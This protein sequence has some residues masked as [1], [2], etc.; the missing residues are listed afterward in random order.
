MATT[1]TVTVTLVGGPADWR[2]RTLPYGPDTLAADEPGAYLISDY[3]PHREDWEDTSPRAV[4]TADEDSPRVWRFRGWFPASVHDP[5]PS[6]YDR[7]D[8]A[9]LYPALTRIGITATAVH[10][11]VHT[12]LVDLLDDLDDEDPDE[13]LDALTTAIGDEVDLVDRMIRRTDAETVAR[14]IAPHLA[15][16]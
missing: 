13:R 7:V 10:H 15:D 4:Y 16:E 6:A 11:A 12:R 14:T 8:T 1:D 2:G 5:D 9:I 3:P